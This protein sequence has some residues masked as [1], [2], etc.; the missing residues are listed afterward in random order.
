MSASA[1]RIPTE[2]AELWMMAVNRVATTRPSRGFCSPARIAVNSGICASG[3]TASLITTMPYM[4]MVKPTSTVPMLFCLSFLPTIII[5]TPMMA[6]MGEK[7]SGFSI[8]SHI[9]P[10][11]MPERERIHAVSVVPILA[12]KMTYSVWP[13]FIMPELTRPTS[14][15]VTAEEDCTA[16][17]MAAPSSILTS[18][19]AVI[20]FSSCSSF[21]PAIF[22]RLLDMTLM[23]NRKKARPSTSRSSA[24]ISMFL[25][26]PG[27]ARPFF[28]P[29]IQAH[30][31]SFGRRLSS[32][33]P[34]KYSFSGS[35]CSCINK[36]QT[37]R[38]ALIFFAEYSAGTMALRLPAALPCP[39]AF[40]HKIGPQRK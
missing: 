38:P 15:T 7:F 32:Q 22:S 24:K 4:S 11:W 20:V 30:F 28:Q 17:V 29:R 27:F 40:C 9:L 23:P 39:A 1:C 16:M 12:P 8:F 5:T 33:F 31:T 25:S 19:L 6:R 37:R 35:L 34:A 14:I 26:P 3:L 13:N 36:G 18:G 21:P 2:A 10:L